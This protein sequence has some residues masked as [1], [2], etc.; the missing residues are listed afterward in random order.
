MTKDDAQITCLSIVGSGC[1]TAI[2]PLAL[3]CVH[4]S[5][6]YCYLLHVVDVALCVDAPVE[7]DY[8]V[9]CPHCGVDAIGIS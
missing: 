4:T 8:T 6:G 9:R 7:S 5:A 1:D 2:V 3:L